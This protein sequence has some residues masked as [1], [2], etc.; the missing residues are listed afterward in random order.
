MPIS[1]DRRDIGSGLPH[2]VYAYATHLA[3]VEVDILT[4]KV[5]VIGYCSVSDVGKVI[6]PPVFEGQVEGAVAQGIGA[7]LT[8][9]IKLKDGLAL[10]NNFTTYIVPT[11][12]DVPQIEVI[13][14]ESAEPTGPFGLKGTGEI[15]VDAP[16][17][18]VVSAIENAVGVRVSSLPVSPEE[19][20]KSIEVED[21]IP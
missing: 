12:V 10:N 2:I 9:G 11:A 6:N 7:A 20:I 3:V 19:I 15:N 16:P 13:A 21:A 1:K 18:A 4:G 8:E 5:R 17:A 14:V